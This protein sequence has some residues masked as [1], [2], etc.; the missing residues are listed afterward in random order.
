[1]NMIDL[2]DK[3]PITISSHDYDQL[4]RIAMAGV[5]GSRYPRI[6]QCLVDELARAAVVPVHEMDAKVVTMC[7]DLTFRDD[8]TGDF[9]RV[10][11]V[12]PGEEDIALGRISILTPVGTALI[13]LSEGQAIG[14]R[15]A[16]GEPRRLTV[17]RVYSRRTAPEQERG[18][19]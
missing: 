13:G 14:W 16:T 6:A 7:S 19:I 18:G 15:T 2:Y 5:R 17:M 8:T 1:M 3:P 4:E 12:Y 11:L 10:T 9:R